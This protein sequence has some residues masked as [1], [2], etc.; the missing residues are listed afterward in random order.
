MSSSNDLFVLVAISDDKNP[1]RLVGPF[2]DVSQANQYMQ[3]DF[4]QVSDAVK[5]DGYTVVFEMTDDEDYFTLMWTSDDDDRHHSMSW[6]M[7][8]P[9]SPYDQS[10]TK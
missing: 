2:S 5:R 6:T 8:V 9:E 1:P 3:D 7:L 10:T 4:L